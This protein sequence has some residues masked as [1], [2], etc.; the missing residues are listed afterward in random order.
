[1]ADFDRSRKVIVEREQIDPPAYNPFGDLSL[2][3]EIVDLLPQMQS[4]VDKGLVSKGFKRCKE[5]ARGVCAAKAGLPRPCQPMK[6]GCDSVCDKLSVCFGKRQSNGERH[7][8][9]RHDLTLKR[10]A[11]DIDQTGQHQQSCRIN[12]RGRGVTAGFK[13]DVANGVFAKDSDVRQREIAACEASSITN[14]DQCNHHVQRSEVAV[15]I[16]HCSLTTAHFE[17][18]CRGKMIGAVTQ[19]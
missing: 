4:V 15:A 5:C 9:P 2:G 18:I 7:C 17:S 19:M 13:L 6:R 3:V 1:M 8:R 16:F 10:I 12:R 14:K 11:V